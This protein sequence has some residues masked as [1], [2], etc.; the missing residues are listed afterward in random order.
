MR[1]DDRL[2]LVDAQWLA[3]AEK[4][5]GTIAKGRGLQPEN[6]GEENSRYFE[7]LEP[8]PRLLADEQRRVVAKPAAPNGA[9][10]S[11]TQRIGA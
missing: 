1:G 11:Q 6:G 8:V 9:A 3:T 2:S 5:A 7:F 10:E 4:R